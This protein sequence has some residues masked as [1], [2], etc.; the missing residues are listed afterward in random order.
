MTKPISPSEITTKQIEMIPDRIIEVWNT[1][2]AQKFNGTSATVYQ[3]EI[4]SA[5]QAAWDADERYILTQGWLDIEEIYRQVGWM[6][7]YV[8]RGI[9]DNFESH[10]IFTR[11]S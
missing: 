1:M 11:K 9:G 7:E 4:I 2:L 3:R 6:V 5:I 10:F 8:K